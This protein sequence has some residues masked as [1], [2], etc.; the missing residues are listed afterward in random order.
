MDEEREREEAKTH[1]C[2]DMNIFQFVHDSYGR[3][4]K[5]NKNE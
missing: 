3:Y 4:N 2:I 1:A 5:N